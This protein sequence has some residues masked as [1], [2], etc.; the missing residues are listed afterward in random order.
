MAAAHGGKCRVQTTTEVLHDVKI[1]IAD[2]A[3]FFSNDDERRTSVLPTPPARWVSKHT[4]TMA[5]RALRAVVRVASLRRVSRVSSS[6]VPCGEGFAPANQA[7]GDARPPQRT[8]TGGQCAKTVVLADVGHGIG[9]ALLAALLEYP[10]CRLTVA[11]A[12]PSADLVT[13][14]RNQHWNE[15]AGDQCSVEKVDLGDDAAVARWREKVLFTHGPP[16]I[17]I[18]NVGCMPT[19]WGKEFGGDDTG[20][21]KGEKEGSKADTPETKD[22][23]KGK[24]SEGKKSVKSDP[25]R[26]DHNKYAAWRTKPEDWS[27]MLNDVKGVSVVARQ[28]L[29]TMVGDC[30][31]A[32]HQNRKENGSDEDAA[33]E[34]ETSLPVNPKLFVTVSHV[35]DPPIASRLAPYRA[36]HAALCAV[37]ASIASDLRN[38]HSGHD[39]KDCSQRIIALQ[40]DP[41]KGLSQLQMPNPTTVCRVFR[42][43]KYITH[44]TTQL[45]AHTTLTLFFFPSRRAPRFGQRN[46]RRRRRAF[47]Q[48]ARRRGVGLS[49]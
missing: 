40:I 14:L 5:L 20:D 22:T 49:H 39:A 3:V 21:T 42:V 43:Q 25:P 1:E 46:R 16:A 44:G 37:T 2:S 6:F 32:N 38:A 12:T 10:D 9:R 27:R 30:V 34:T 24:K 47:A 45:F 7:L 33:S 26:D 28:F 36:S 18:A 19:R 41:G 11:A 8:T 17:V 23:R 29:P 15:C 48:N 4:R 31:P 35:I 13:S